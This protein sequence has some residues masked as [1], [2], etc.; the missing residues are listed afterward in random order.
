MIS[1]SG[2]NFFY[3]SENCFSIVVNSDNHLAFLLFLPHQMTH[4]F[5]NKQLTIAL[6]IAL[7]NSDFVY[8]VNELGRVT[9]LVLC[10]QSP[11]NLHHFRLAMGSK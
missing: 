3:E 9:T 2:G 8:I 10:R 7:S 4:V 6:H 1:L 5:S 11:L